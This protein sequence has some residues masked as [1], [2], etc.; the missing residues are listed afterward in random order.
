V[1][2]ALEP[3]AADVN[4]VAENVKFPASDEPS[5]EIGGFGNLR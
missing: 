2:L 1:D 5:I 4:T 3:L